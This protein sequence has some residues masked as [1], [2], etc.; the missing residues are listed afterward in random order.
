MDFTTLLKL[1]MENGDFTR[2]MRNPFA[3]FE[4]QLLRKT[5]LGAQFLPERLI[6][7]GNNMIKEEELLFR[8]IVAED[9][10]RYDPIPLRH[11]E[12]AFEM[13]VEMG[14]HDIGRE[15]KGSQY[16]AILKLLA[17]ADSNAARQMIFSLVDKMINHALKAKKEKQRWEAIVNK[18]VKVEKSNGQKYDVDIQYPAENHLIAPAFFDDPSVDPFEIV[19]EGIRILKKKGFGTIEAIVSTCDPIAAM[20][21][22]EQVKGRFGGIRVDTSNNSVTPVNRGVV[23]KSLLNQTMRDE[24]YPGFTE[25]NEGYNTEEEFFSYL[26]NHTVTIIASTERMEETIVPDGKDLLIPSTL[27]Y[28]GV[29]TCQGQTEP[30]DVVKIFPKEDKPVRVEAQGEGV[31]FPV[32]LET[33]AIVN[34]FNCVPAA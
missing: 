1:M 3:Q 15:I 23:G 14:H 16:D 13:Y 24:G 7:D 34:I 4:A 28:Y 18:Q 17:N 19:F 20:M 25:Y 9:S 33:K 2:I 31:G 11:K 30:G 6:L 12:E 29:G 32:P 10:G 26:P 8:T 5:Y 27:G 21:K 22:N